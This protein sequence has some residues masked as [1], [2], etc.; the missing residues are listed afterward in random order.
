MSAILSLQPAQ[1][2]VGKKL[3]KLATAFLSGNH[4]LDFYGYQDK[5]DDR[6]I[7]ESVTLTGQSIDIAEL[8]SNQQLA[9]FGYHCDRNPPFGED[10][11]ADDRTEAYAMQREEVAA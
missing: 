7:V 2:T 4:Y 8:F 1:P 3:V 6:Y 9:D 11:A 10:S 5:H